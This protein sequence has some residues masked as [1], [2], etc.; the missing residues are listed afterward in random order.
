MIQVT[1]R[2]LTDS[3]YRD[4]IQWFSNDGFGV[5][6]T[7]LRDE[8]AELEAKAGEAAVDST[9]RDGEV[10]AFREQVIFLRSVIELMD[11]VRSKDRELFRVSLTINE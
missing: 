2:P 9:N 4:V 3:E 6:R 11:S 1:R 8:A 10:V 7:C 5:F